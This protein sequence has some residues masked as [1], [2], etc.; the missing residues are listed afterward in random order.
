[1]GLMAP[2]TIHA[3]G[4]VNLDEKIIPYGRID[5]N[6]HALNSHVLFKQQIIIYTITIDYFIGGISSGNLFF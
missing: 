5:S 2:A 3:E 6:T 1:M 4:D